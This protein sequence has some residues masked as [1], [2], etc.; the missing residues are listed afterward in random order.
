MCKEVDWETFMLYEEMELNYPKISIPFSI[1]EPYLL[2]EFNL[3]LIIWNLSS[4]NLKITKAVV[5]YVFHNFNK[6]F[7]TA[8]TALYYYLCDVEPYPDVA[9]HTLREFYEEQ[10]D[11]ESSYYSIQLEINS[12]HLSDGMARY[13][14]VVK[15]VCDYRKW[16]IS[17]DDMRVYMVGNKGCGFDTNNDDL[18]ILGDYEFLYENSDSQEIFEKVYE[19][20]SCENF[21]FAEPFCSV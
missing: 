16:M 2:K 9:N 1:K 5:S 4:E 6:L 21:V 13:C 15:T 8:W 11:F 7:E 17:N 20:M 18:Q 10:I 3:D 12:E 19:K 14:F